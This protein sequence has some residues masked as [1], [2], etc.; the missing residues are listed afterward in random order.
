LH[1][2]LD[3]FSKIISIARGF[4][5]RHIELWVQ[6]PEPDPRMLELNPANLLEPCGKITVLKG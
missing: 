4:I 1:Y 6:S 2:L 3:S 5:A